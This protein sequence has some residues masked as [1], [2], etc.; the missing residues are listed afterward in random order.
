MSVSE[1]AAYWQ[2]ADS[3]HIIRAFKKRY[4]LTPTEYA[5]STVPPEN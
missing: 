1:L 2:F 3:S 4:G 5:R